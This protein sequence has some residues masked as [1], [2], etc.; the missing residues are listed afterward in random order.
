MTDWDEKARD[1]GRRRSDVFHD[2]R[3][4]WDADLRKAVRQSCTSAC[5][6]CA[7]ERDIATAL[8]DAHREGLERAAKECGRH[9]HTRDACALIWALID[10]GEE[11]DDGPPAD[12]AGYYRD[13]AAAYRA[14]A[15]ERGALLDRIRLA[16]TDAGVPEMSPQGDRGLSLVRRIQVLVHREEARVRRASRCARCGCDLDSHDPPDHDAGG[17]GAC[18][19][20]PCSRYVG[21]AR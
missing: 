19:G 5:E 15:E 11:P 17:R 1:L 7:A 18:H 3:H 8:R 12:E 14:T 4:Y 10:G 21:V 9:L 2:S 20:C 13:M 6:A 16:L